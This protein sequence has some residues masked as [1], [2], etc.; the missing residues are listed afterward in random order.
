MNDE[1]AVQQHHH[2][3]PT[4]TD[5]ED[6]D[7]RRYES[8]VASTLLTSAMT[9]QPAVNDSYMLASPHQLDAALN[10]LSNI[11]LTG[12]STSQ[13]RHA[14]QFV[15]VSAGD[16]LR[17]ISLTGPMNLPIRTH[18]H[19]HHHHNHHHHH[20][21]LNRRSHRKLGSS[22]RKGSKRRATVV[23]SLADVMSTS[24]DVSALAPAPAA[25]ATPTAPS[26]TQPASDAV[27]PAAAAAA[28][29]AIDGRGSDELDASAMRGV[30]QTAHAGAADTVPADDES[31]SASDRDDDLLRVRD[32]VA[33]GDS[34]GSAF[35]RSTSL[36]DSAPNYSSPDA[37]D[38]SDFYPSPVITS[39]IINNEAFNANDE[40]AI[41]DATA[42][43]MSSA[44]LALAAD[45]AQQAAD[46]DAAVDLRRSDGMPPE[47]D[48]FFRGS[49]RKPVS[50]RLAASLPAEH[51][52]AEP[53]KVPSKRAAAAAVAG[54]SLTPAE[55]IAKYRNSKPG[56][57]APPA[58]AVA[59]STAAAPSSTTATAPTAT[60]AASAVV[61]LAR[62]RAKPLR[63]LPVG[64]LHEAIKGRTTPQRVFVC[65]A[66]SG[67]AVPPT[68]LSVCTYLPFVPPRRRALGDG[69]QATAAA[70]AEA[71]V[72]ASAVAVAGGRQRKKAAAAQSIAPLLQ[73]SWLKPPPLSLGGD[74][75][76]GVPNVYSATFLDD[77]ALATG[78]H[79]VVMQ[80]CGLTTTVL[81][82]VRPK[83]LKAEL[84]SAFA[85]RH[86]WLTIKLTQLRKVKKLMLQVASL[87]DLEHSTL[88]LAYVYLDKALLRKFCANKAALLLAGAAALVLATKFNDTAGMDKAA[89]K[90][91]LA[92]LK[93]V[94]AL[95]A[96]EVHSTEMRLWFALDCHLFVPSA[97][98]LQ[99]LPAVRGAVAS[100]E[101]VPQPTSRRKAAPLAALSRPNTIFKVK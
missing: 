68:L 8:I 31:R 3:S 90:K 37:L 59:P 54:A 35:V 7:E 22:V 58:S 82:Y 95:D 89:Y 98:V 36:A 25:D 5:D 1:A 57:T 24:T 45:E 91:L 84:N 32:E 93:A 53:V 76:L 60:A 13:Q 33:G 16:F 39:T 67:A 48:E 85:R 79:R 86:P 41:A 66:G 75:Q 28:A 47:V 63:V 62:A 12:A 46:A 49:G 83:R 23:A 4:S 18:H 21:Q 29:A 6:S 92:H 26:S 42:A 78:K 81:P 19:H 65:A 72:A 80:L 9:Q 71:G 56:S 40:A 20:H 43:S 15:A 27:A 10:F 2:E 51:S 77:P 101:V 64:R 73:P 61:P 14:P 50:R 99:H 34:A 88:A 96:R 100:A 74:D 69:A 55:R 70:S 30:V 94:M 87:A 17:N 38:D 11:S 44:F 97:E 52:G